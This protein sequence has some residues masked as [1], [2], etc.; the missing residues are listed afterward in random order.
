MKNLCAFLILALIGTAGVFAQDV[1]GK[2]KTI[3]DETGDAKSIGN[4]YV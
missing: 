4:I 2:W 1:T 3:D